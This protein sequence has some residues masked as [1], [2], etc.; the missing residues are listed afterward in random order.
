[1]QFDSLQALWEM[2]G[3]G[4]FVWMAYL[5]TFAVAFSLILQPVLKRRRLLAAIKIQHVLENE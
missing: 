4:Y 1:M 2:G 3:H 5:I